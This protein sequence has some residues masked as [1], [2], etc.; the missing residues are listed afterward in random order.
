MHPNQRVHEPKKKEDKSHVEELVK[1]VEH[2]FDDDLHVLKIAQQ[3]EYSNHSERLE[4]L[5]RVEGVVAVTVLTRE[6]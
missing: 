1:G 2:D 5:E 3:P 4:G 6:V